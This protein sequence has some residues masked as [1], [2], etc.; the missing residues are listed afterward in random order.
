ML[1]DEKI[2]NKGLDLAMEWGEN[3]LQPIQ[4]HLKKLLKIFQQKQLDEYNRICRSVM[5]EGQKMVYEMA[6]KTGCNGVR[7]DEWKVKMLQSYPWINDDNIS[8]LYSQGM[9]Y[10]WKDGM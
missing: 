9:Y 2:L 4:E 5:D 6:E 3:R 8:H 10:A 1:P 7:I